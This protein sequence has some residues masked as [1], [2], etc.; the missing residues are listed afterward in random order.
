MLNQLFFKVGRMLTYGRHGQCWR[1]ELAILPWPKRYA[2][3]CKYKK[4]GLLGVRYNKIQITS[5]VDISCEK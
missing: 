3:V 5:D 4:Q 2:P 1:A